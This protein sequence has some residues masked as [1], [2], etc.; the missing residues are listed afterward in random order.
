MFKQGY[1][2]KER[3]EML[4]E[5]GFEWQVKHPNWMGRYQELIDFKSTHGH[6]RTFGRWVHDQRKSF[7]QGNL[8]KERIEML[9]EIGFA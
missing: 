3:I 8:S 4:K 9:K 6:C 2:S 5:I 1:L 7:K